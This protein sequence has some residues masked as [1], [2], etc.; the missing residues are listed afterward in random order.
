[1]EVDEDLAALAIRVVERV[2]DRG[3][4][5]VIADDDRPGERRRKLVPADIG[6]SATHRSMNA[7]IQRLLPSRLRDVRVDTPERWQ[8]LERRVFVAVHPLSGVIKP[9][10]FDLETGRLC[11]MASRHKAGL[12]VVTRDHVGDTLDN[13]ITTAD[14]AVGRP[15]VSGRGH[16]QHRSFWAQI[17]NSGRIVAAT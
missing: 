11:V 12:V 5:A 16:F 1:M 6:I 4:E 2:L 17:A 13:L 8:G 14:Q 15:D 7:A 10:A 3:A 9:A